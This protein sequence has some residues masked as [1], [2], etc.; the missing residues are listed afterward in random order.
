MIFL[1]LNLMKSANHYSKI[2]E[3]AVYTLSPNL[4]VSAVVSSV[5]PDFK[6]IDLSIVTIC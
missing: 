2:E 5:I 6:V 4:N 3:A 1:P